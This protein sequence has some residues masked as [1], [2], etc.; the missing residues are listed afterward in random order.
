MDLLV[1]QMSSPQAPASPSSISETTQV[2]TS[3]TTSG[4]L[5]CKSLDPDLKEDFNRPLHG[6]P[7]LAKTIEQ[8][9]DFEAFPT[10]RDLNIKSLLYYQCQLNKMRAELHELEW[11]DHRDSQC[12]EARDFNSRV[13]FLITSASYPKED[14]AREQIDL[15]ERIRVVLEKYNSALLQY[16]EIN[17]LPRA[18]SLNVSSLRHWLTDPSQGKPQISG[19]GATSWGELNQEPHPSLS[20]LSQFLHLFDFRSHNK[21]GMKL[22]LVVPRKY[23]K[24]DGLTL[25]VAHKW[26]PFWQ[27]LPHFPR[28]SSK[29]RKPSLSQSNTCP[30]HDIENTSSAE[31]EKGVPGRKSLRRKISQMFQPSKPC[32]P[33]NSDT[34]IM[35]TLDTYSMSAMLRFTSFVAT[36][37]ACL[38]PTVAISVLSTV[39]TTAKLL[40]YIALF[41]SIFAMGLMGLTDSG[42]SRTEIFTATAAFSAVLVVFVQNQS[43]VS[44]TTY[45]NAAANGTNT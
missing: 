18:D 21:D 22:D 36:V 44:T 14:V 1:P 41:T 37:V 31:R 3:P 9:P 4:C 26:I 35:P 30:L 2:S 43:G 33:E 17:A 8:Y 40:G 39:H 23:E 42:T 19:P 12:P 28:W 16:S 34:A 25:W 27:N 24:V 15:I 45:I 32:E 7:E 10:F 5:H 13:D 20:F 6:W 11:E 29:H 38:L